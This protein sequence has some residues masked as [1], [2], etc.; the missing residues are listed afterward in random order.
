MGCSFGVTHVGTQFPSSICVQ[1]R[2]CAIFHSTKGTVVI[3]FANTIKTAMC[4]MILKQNGK[5]V[6]RILESLWLCAKCFVVIIKV[7][8]SMSETSFCLVV[9]TVMF[10]T[11]VKW[12]VM[13]RMIGL[14]VRVCNV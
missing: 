12:D 9:H 6:L 13:E 11:P 3:Y 1:Y 5:F 14:F 7:F 2:I 4:S 10:A 8:V